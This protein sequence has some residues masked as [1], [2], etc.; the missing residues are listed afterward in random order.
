M[1]TVAVKVLTVKT[2]YKCSSDR[3]T[4]N[5]DN[6]EFKVFTLRKAIKR[7]ASDTLYIFPMNHNCVTRRYDTLECI[8]FICRLKLI[9]LGLHLRGIAQSREEL[10]LAGH[11]F[12]FRKSFRKVAVQFR[13]MLRKRSA[14]SAREIC[15]SRHWRAALINGINEISSLRGDPLRGLLILGA[16][17][18]IDGPVIREKER[19]R[20]AVH[21]E[22]MKVHE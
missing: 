12:R 6:T 17:G 13:S 18:N 10:A 20:G 8:E 4:V 21:R 22:M 5:D 11:G 14:A 9:V 7:T 1:T 2:L 19:K 3:K 15:G 16:V